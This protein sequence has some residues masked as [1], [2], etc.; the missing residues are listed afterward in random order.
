VEAIIL[1]SGLSSE[2]GGHAGAHAVHNGLTTLPQAGAALH[3]EKVA[4]GVLVQLV[5][6]GRTSHHLRE[7]QEFCFSVGLPRSLEAL[8]V[9]HPSPAQV[10]EVA[11]ATV[12]PEETIHATWFPVTAA[13]VEEAIWTADSLGM[14]YEREKR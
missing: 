4:F 10:R 3:G 2:N 14:S 9:V 7:V 13:M 12:A 1:L 6:E 11:A 5:L 8:C